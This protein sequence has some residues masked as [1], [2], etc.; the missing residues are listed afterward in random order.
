MP[1]GEVCCLLAVCCPPE[2]RRE[3]FVKALVKDGQNEA[4]ATAFVD[5]TLERFD[6]APKG[7]M[8]ELISAVGMMARAH[9]ADEHE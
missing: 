3:K 4:A 6:L 7:T 5:W 8:D 1:N 9:G 2:R